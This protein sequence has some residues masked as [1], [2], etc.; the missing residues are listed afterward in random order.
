MASTKVRVIVFTIIACTILINGLFW[1][2][3][4]NAGAK[5]IEIGYWLWPISESPYVS[6]PGETVPDTLYVEVAEYRQGKLYTTWPEK[7]PPASRYLAVIRVEGTKTPE[8][9]IIPEIIKQYFRL[10]KMASASGQQLAGLQIDFDC[11]T[12][13]LNTYADFLKNLRTALTKEDILSITALIDW[14]EA[15]NRIADVIKWIDEYV[16]QFYDVSTINENRDDSGIAMNIDQ[17]KWGP[18]FNS[19]GRPYRIGIS[20]FGR[21]SE[22]EE[23]I[24]KNSANESSNSKRTIK[25]RYYRY[26]S[27]WDIMRYGRYQKISERQSSS[28]ERIVL[29]KRTDIPNYKKKLKITIPT[30]KSLRSA[31][32]AAK[33]MGGQ[34]KGVV[35]YRWP[36]VTESMILTPDEINN[37]IAN[38]NEPD[39]T[40]VEVQDGYCSVVNCMDLYI[41]LVERFPDKPV[42]LQIRSSSDL[43][44]FIPAESIK[45]K[46]TG[47]MTIEILAPA[48]AGSPRIYIGRAVASGP[49]R[50]GVEE[51]K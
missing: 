29:L 24:K 43:Q 23:G 40:V 12:A 14:F 19:Y 7:V 13:K 6:P 30:K 48:Y 31:Y 37:A 47:S 38:K 1:E 2:I 46:Q 49:L 26:S 11:P 3:L 16:P 18:V 42:H 20:V 44:Y 32:E 50:F 8:T 51:I 35:F 10:K 21:L 25:E 28:G 22:I 27:L 36:A 33:A 5:Q 4:V 39:R 17:A 45:G 15:N 34:C 41:G 9:L